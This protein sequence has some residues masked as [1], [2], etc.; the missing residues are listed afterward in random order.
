MDDGP[1]QWNPTARGG[2]LN[3][4]RQGRWIP[5]FAEMTKEA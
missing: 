5:G 3:A 1:S 4:G 2:L